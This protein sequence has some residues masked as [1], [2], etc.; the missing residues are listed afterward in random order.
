MASFFFVNSKMKNVNKQTNKQN[1]RRNWL[2]PKNMHQARQ[3]NINEL[4]KTR[5]EI[6]F[7]VLSGHWLKLIR[8]AR[9][10]KIYDPYEFFFFFFSRLALLLLLL[11]F[12]RAFR[13]MSSMRDIFHTWSIYNKLQI[14]VKII[15]MHRTVAKKKTNGNWES[16]EYQTFFWRTFISCCRNQTKL[17]KQTNKK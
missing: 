14:Y 16:F 8:P 17:N 4:N 12:L 2:R 9:H 13:L 3:T 6:H 1:W 5:K 10:I 15:S 7:N 11:L